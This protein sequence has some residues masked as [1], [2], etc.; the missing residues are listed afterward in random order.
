MINEGVHAYDGPWR[1]AVQDDFVRDG[2]AVL[3]GQKIRQGETA[4]VKP[5]E[6]VLET[7]PEPV[8]VGEPSLRLPDGL[9]RALL[10][11]LASHYG[12]ASDLRRLRSDYDA[13]RARVD[14][15]IGHLISGS[16]AR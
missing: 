2:V 12:G 7:Q 4:V 3:L 5:V 14:R 13:E 10:D 6:M 8:Y 15:M 1:A 9:A 11:A 16:G